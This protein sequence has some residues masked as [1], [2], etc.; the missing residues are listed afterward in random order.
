MK[1]LEQYALATG[2]KVGNQS[3][4]EA[5]YPLPFDRY[6]T[7]QNG[8]GSQAKSYSFFNEVLA[9]MGP[10]LKA[11]GIETVQLGG[12]DDP[13][14]NGCHHTQGQTSIHQS[15]FILRRSM[16]HIAN[17]SW[18]S[19]RA[20]ALGVPLVTCYGPTS[21][22][23]HSPYI[24][25]PQKTLLIE[26]H[27]C[28]KRPT[29][30]AQE[31][32][33]TVDLIPPEQI[34]NA[35]LLLLGLPQV[36]RKTLYV[37]EVFNQHLVELVPNVIVDPKVNIVG[38]MVIRMDL[39]HD[40]SIMMSNLQVRKCAIAINKEVNLNILTQLKGNIASLRI[41]VDSLSPEWLRQVKRLGVPTA[42]VSH[43][44][45]PEKLAALRLKLYDACLFDHYMPRTKEDFFKEGKVYLNKELDSGL[46]FGTLQFKTYRMILSDGKV[47]LSNAHRLAGKNTPSSEQNTGQVIDDPEFWNDLGSYLI[48]Q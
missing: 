30:A 33:R 1:L 13:A 10:A 21:I 20:G 38:A 27:R 31:S 18:L 25:D 11:A 14:L 3:L 6:I 7:I 15:S 4:H 44:Q 47:Y 5:F 22:E 29:F 19:H 48:Y 28:G 26:S 34:A 36:A 16:V 39:H 46:N 40:E 32:P 8:A 43:E 12:K 41:Q 9:I 17:D 24:F 45:D 37:G 35:A 2:L 23:N 42:Y